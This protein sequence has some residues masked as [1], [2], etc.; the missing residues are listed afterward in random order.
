MQ[1]TPQLN[2]TPAFTLRPAQA[3]DQEIIRRFVRGAG[4]N[5]TGLAWPR[6]VM[7]V[8][9]QGQVIGCAQ[10]KPHRDGSR[11]FASLVVAEAW[12]GRGVA[13]V[14]IEH[15]KAAAGPPLYLMCGSRLV[16][17]YEKFGFREVDQDEPLPAYFHRIRRLA[18]LFVRLKRPAEYLAI[19][20]W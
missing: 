17:L 10:V 5:P 13:R 12:R 8:D 15:L 1:Q 4:L 19:M 11:E 2:A 6:F 7:A 16:P 9:P 18:S 20:V 14:L 3:T